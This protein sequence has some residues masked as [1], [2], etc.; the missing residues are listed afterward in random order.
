MAVGLFESMQANP[1]HEQR[2]QPHHEGNGHDALDG[3]PSSDVAVTDRGDRGQSKIESCATA[4]L[5]K[6]PATTVHI[7]RR[8]LH[9]SAHAMYWSIELASTRLIPELPAPQAPHV[10]SPL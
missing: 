6:L 10:V 1:W 9:N 7:F 3:G 4:L 2:Q 8:D 5:G